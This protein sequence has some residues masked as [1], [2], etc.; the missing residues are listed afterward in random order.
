[1]EKI[2]SRTKTIQEDKVSGFCP[3]CM[4]S[5]VNKLIAEVLDE[6]GIEGK[7]VGVAPVGCSVF[8]YNYFEYLKV[9]EYLFW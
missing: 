6:L 1:M 5:T 7:T 8:A 3:G 9:I 2:Y 4:H